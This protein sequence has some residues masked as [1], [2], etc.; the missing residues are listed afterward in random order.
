MRV[1]RGDQI[2][3]LDALRLRAYFRRYGDNVN[4][5]TLR[6]EFSLTK[7]Q[8]ENVM[9]ALVN[10]KMIAACE[11]QHDKKM[12]C[13]ETT[14]QGNALGMAKASRP[15][16]RESA[17]TVLTALMLRGGQAVDLKPV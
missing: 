15:V 13:Y 7:E 9:D 12:I 10:L 6:Q 17:E 14:I 1:N 2:A 8:A 3:G 4:W 5:R 16:K 11:F